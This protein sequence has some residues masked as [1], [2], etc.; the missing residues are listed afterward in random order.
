MKNKKLSK[1][2]EAR[3]LE[4]RRD[5]ARNVIADRRWSCSEISFYKS[6]ITKCSD[7]I[8][9]L[10]KLQDSY[11]RSFFSAANAA[12]KELRMIGNRKAIEAFDKE[13]IAGIKFYVEEVRDIFFDETVP[14][15]KKCNC[16]AVSRSSNICN[17]FEQVCYHFVSEDHKHYF[18][19]CIPGVDDVENLMY[20]LS[21]PDHGPRN[22]YELWNYGK[23]VLSCDEDGEEYQ[24]FS[25]YDVEEFRKKLA[26]I[27]SNSFKE[28]VPEKYGKENP[29]PEEE[30]CEE[31]F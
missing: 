2:D 19:V 5:F 25:T 20:T 29:G 11:F 31:N 12:N 10:H 17:W 26:D 24:V 23:L 28:L 9:R 16:I 15:L 1:E 8:E 27:A 21:D 30:E 22:R 6:E 7:E 4:L 18:N 13:G 3:M 14:S